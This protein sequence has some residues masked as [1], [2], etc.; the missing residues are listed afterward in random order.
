M[1][2]K[3]ILNL[4]LALCCLGVS[5][6]S[7]GDE[8]RKPNVL[9]I[10]VDDLRPETGAYGNP[11]IKTPNLDRFAATAAMF[12]N[13]YVQVP[14]CG[15]SRYSLLTGRWP[16]TKQHLQNSAFERFMSGE[17]EKEAPESMVHHFRRHGYYTAGIGKVSHS[18]DGLVY[19]YE[20]SPEGAKREMPYS[21]D[22]FLFNAGKWGTGWNAFFGYADGS[23]RQGKKGKVKP[24]EKG[25]VDDAGYPDGPTADLAVEK[26]RALSKKQ[27]P[28]FLSVGFFK[29]HLPFTAPARYWDLYDREKIPIS[30][31]PDLPAN[32]NLASL[33]KMGE[34]NQYGLGDERAVLDRRLTDAYARKLVHAYY[35]SVSYVD[36][37]IGKVLDELERQ[38][39]ADNTIVVVWGDHGWHLGDHRVWGKHT[40]FEV[41]LRS[42]LMIRVPGMKSVRIPGKHVV[43]S[44]DVYPSLLEWCAL[45]SVSSLDGQ[46][47]DRLMRKGSDRNRENVAFSYFNQGISMRNERYRLIRYFREDR[48]V[49][50]LYDHL[51]DPFES[52]NIAADQPRIVEKLMPLLEKGNTGLYDR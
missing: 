34:F 22:E 16:R 1:F 6:C 47:L 48:P 10:A 43:S 4:A 30:P 50:E 3:I 31:V 32:V 51:E 17:P 12:E 20:E 26:I 44:I 24:Y 15:A 40:N 9:F 45:P 23:N 39:L 14:T 28:F 42:L 27:Q 13:H 33:Q 11:V 7:G 38:G 2:G 46:S 8:K 37:Q 29:P 5:V 25:M 41:A 18:V 35:A 49:I 21:W 52:K 19:G 36:A